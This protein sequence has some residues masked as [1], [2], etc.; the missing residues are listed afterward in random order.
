MSHSFHQS[1]T[2]K[3]AATFVYLC[4]RKRKQGGRP[5]RLFSKD[6]ESLRFYN[7]VRLLCWTSQMNKMNGGIASS[8]WVLAFIVLP[9][10]MSSILLTQEKPNSAPMAGNAISTTELQ[11]NYPAH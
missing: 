4:G 3:I 2:V 9:F 8:E 11:N 6:L 1:R 7:Y 5:T 10:H